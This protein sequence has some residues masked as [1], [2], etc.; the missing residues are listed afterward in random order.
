[1]PGWQEGCFDLDSLRRQP[2]HIGELRELSGAAL[3]A[4]IVG[5]CSG[6]VNQFDGEAKQ[7]TVAAGCGRGVNGGG[8]CNDMG[9]NN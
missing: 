8:G 1:M 7:K 5:D 2:R 4:S 6:L 3:K 9:D